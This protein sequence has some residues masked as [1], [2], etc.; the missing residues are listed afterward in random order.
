MT[1]AG[2]RWKNHTAQADKLLKLLQDHDGQWV[3]LPSILALGIAQYG[4]RIGELR[5][6]GHRIEN[7]TEW[8]EGVRHSWFGLN[9]T[10]R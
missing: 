10:P 8:R 2:R 9:A 3:P 5:K 7:Y 6:A 4:A 1:T